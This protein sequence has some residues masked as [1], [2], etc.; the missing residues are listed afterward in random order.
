MLLLDPTQMSQQYTLIVLDESNNNNNSMQYQL[1]KDTHFVEINGKRQVFGFDGYMNHSCNPNVICKNLSDSL[2]VGIARRDIGVGDEITCDYA[3][4]DYLCDGHEIEVCLCGEEGCRKSMRGFVNLDRKTQLELLP[5]VD[6]GILENFVR[7]Q[8]LVNVGEMS[9]NDSCQV[10]YDEGRMEWKVMARKDLRI[11]DVI[12]EGR[13]LVI[14]EK[15]EKQNVLFLFEGKYYIASEKM[16][17]VQSSCRLFLKGGSFMNG[18]NTPNCLISYL[19]D[20]AYQLKAI[21]DIH[22]HHEITH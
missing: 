22:T 10:V 6:E 20:N 4:F 14:H 13:A 19:N 11:G 12:W 7:D 17:V 1:D 8:K 5:F 2:Y 9:G 15:D 16:F 18:S 3:L 21:R